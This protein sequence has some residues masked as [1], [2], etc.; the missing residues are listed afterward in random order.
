MK[1]FT[2]YHLFRDLFPPLQ[3]SLVD[4]I[5]KAV[6]PEAIFLL[7]ASLHRRRS[8]S[9]FL[10]SA[11]TSH[12]ISDC[13]LLILMED[14]AGKEIHEWQDKI[15]NN[16]KTLMPVTTIVLQRSGFEDWLKENHP[17]AASVQQSALP[18]Y[19]SG[20]F[21]YPNSNTITNDGTVKLPEI[22]PS[23]GLIKAKEFLAGSDLFRIR[24]QNTLA[25]FMLHQSAEQALRTLLKIGTGYHVNTHNID[26]LIRYA[27]LV[28]YQLPDIFPQKTEQQKRLFGLLQR[29]YVDARYKEDYKI[30]TDD[31]LYLAE[32]VQQIHDV[33]SAIGK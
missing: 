13:F 26:R 31:L 1:P 5:V 33:L 16:C 3:K 8:E 18:I 27:G 19:N 25:A 11:P 29:A 23:E 2:I 15:E 17:F 32:K 21:N 10:Q 22:H 24:N 14:L 6:K 30:S 28:S 20:N 12:H 7:G 9:I 4:I